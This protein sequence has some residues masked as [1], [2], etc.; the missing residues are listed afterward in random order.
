MIR[1]I[2]LYLDRTYVLASPAVLSLW[3]SG[4]QLFRNAVVAV[5]GVRTR[6]VAVSFIEKF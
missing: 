3:D 1:S 2:C 5:A 4:L 6:L